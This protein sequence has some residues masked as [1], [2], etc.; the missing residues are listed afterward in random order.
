MHQV[1]HLLCTQAEEVAYVLVS[2]PAPGGLLTHVIGHAKV[3]LINFM[4]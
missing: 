3:L 1:D 4:K 2:Q